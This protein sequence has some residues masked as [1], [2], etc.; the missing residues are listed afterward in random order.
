MV[1]NALN[2]PTYIL[3]QCFSH[4]MWPSQYYINILNKYFCV[5]LLSINLFCWLAHLLS[6]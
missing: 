3:S 6:V 4:Y 1:N 5:S 2:N